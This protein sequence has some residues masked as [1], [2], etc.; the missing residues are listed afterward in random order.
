MSRT[1]E[2]KS[3]KSGEREKKARARALD[4]KKIYLPI[5]ER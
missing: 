5:E 3:E 2:L 1:T 4:K